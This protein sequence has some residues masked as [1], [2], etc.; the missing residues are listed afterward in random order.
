MK[1]EC[2]EALHQLGAYLDGEFDADA[3]AGIS[4]HLA[5]CYPCGDH[6]EFQ[7]HLRVVVRT[8]VVERAPDA[9][10]ERVNLTCFG[11]QPT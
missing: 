11:Q 7:R 2:R 8:R 4:A 10:V 1:P 5:A 6:A 3:I 9:L